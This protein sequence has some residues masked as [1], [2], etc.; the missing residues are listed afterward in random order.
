MWKQIK[1]DQWRWGRRQSSGLGQVSP[2]ALT[3]AKASERKM[4]PLILELATSV[5]WFFSYSHYHF[6]LVFFNSSSSFSQNVNTDVPRVVFSCC[7]IFT[8][9]TSQDSLQH[10]NDC[11]ITYIPVTSNSP[12][13]IQL[14]IHSHISNLP[15]SF[16]RTHTQWVPTKMIILYSHVSSCTSSVFAEVF[17]P[18]S[19]WV[20]SSSGS[21]SPFPSLEFSDLTFH[22]YFFFYGLSFYFYSLSPELIQWPSQRVPC[23]KLNMHL[24]NNLVLILLQEWW[25]KLLTLY[26]TKIKSKREKPLKIPPPRDNH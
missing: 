16:K 21:S 14:S 6:I 1:Q 20:L 9:Y 5:S 23:Y 3:L 2:P 13:L 22:L 10:L 7:F 24:K 18:H 12:S 15:E 4:F 17:V 8:L 19:M 11:S 25:K 26:K